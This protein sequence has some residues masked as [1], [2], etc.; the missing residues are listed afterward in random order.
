MG[1]NIVRPVIVYELIR[2][3]DMQISGEVG[4]GGGGGGGAGGAIALPAGLKKGA[5]NDDRG[6]RAAKQNNTNRH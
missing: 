5:P 3:A 1:D 2:I 6:A 4:L